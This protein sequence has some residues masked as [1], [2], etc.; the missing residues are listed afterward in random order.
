MGK[1]YDTQILKEAARLYIDEGLSFEQVSAHFKGKPSART[2][3]RWSRRKDQQWNHE[4]ERR[5]GA[6]MQIDRAALK[7]MSMEIDGMTHPNAEVRT[8]SIA[9]F[10]KLAS[11]RA[12]IGTN[13]VDTIPIALKLGESLVNLTLRRVAEVTPPEHRQAVTDA[14]GKLMQEWYRGII[15]NPKAVFD[16]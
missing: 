5:V 3:E 14:I 6:P 15:D 7:A 4:R 16:A 10:H 2:I 11:A 1:T 13:R 8:K 12:A 9:N